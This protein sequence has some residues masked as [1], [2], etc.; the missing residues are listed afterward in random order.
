MVFADDPEEFRCDRPDVGASTPQIGN[1]VRV[2]LLLNSEERSSETCEQLI[3][4][5]LALHGAPGEPGEICEMNSCMVR[6]RFVSDHVPHERGSAAISVPS[7]QWA[8][9]GSRGRHLS[10][11]HWWRRRRRY[12]LPPR[13]HVGQVRVERHVGFWA[14]FNL[15]HGSRRIASRLCNPWSRPL[16]RDPRFQPLIG[17]RA[18]VWG[19]CWESSIWST[20]NSSWCCT[21]LVLDDGDTD[22]LGVAVPALA[23]KH[24]PH[25]EDSFNAS[26]CAPRVGDT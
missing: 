6:C 11:L 2:D 5:H 12:R 24:V 23:V 9:V 10:D 16:Y 7:Y 15:V 21:P 25:G 3:L 13:C 26:P 4:Q 22:G 14:V 8:L 20:S 19:I 18:V 17:D 1:A